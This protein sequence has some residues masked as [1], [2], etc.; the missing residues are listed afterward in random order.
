M[1][2]QKKIIYISEEHYNILWN[3]GA[4]DGSFTKNGVTYYYDE[5]ATYYVPFAG[6][7]GGSGEKVLVF[8]DTLWDSSSINGEIEIPSNFE[9]E[10]YLYKV[11]LHIGWEEYEG[12]F[13]FTKKH[14]YSDGS[15]YRFT[16]GQLEFESYVAETSDGGKFLIFYLV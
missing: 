8:P 15:F 2:H 7:N 12:V 1:S 5:D 4:K 9:S 16:N 6:G 14:T 10:W 13:N 11:I 3:N